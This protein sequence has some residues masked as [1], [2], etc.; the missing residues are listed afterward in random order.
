MNI[1]PDL[2][3]K[4]LWHSMYAIA[5]G[6]P[7]ENA[8]P[9][10]KKAASDFF[11]SLIILFPS[12]ECKCKIHYA[13]LLQQNP[14]DLHLEDSD[15]LSRWVYKLHVE[16]NKNIGKSCQPY[17]HIK[18]QFHTSVPSSQGF[19]IGPPSFEKKEQLS[20]VKEEE[21]IEPQIENK[22]IQ[23]NPPENKSI[24]IRLGVPV[25]QRNCNCGKK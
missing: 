24:S 7:N 19:K 6:Y 3:G 13:T 20:I 12:S 23:I 8:S 21:H 15:S 2:F 14:I 4:E 25:P 18:S 16:T 17:E 11:N 22:I 9:E 1:S 5:F 10:H